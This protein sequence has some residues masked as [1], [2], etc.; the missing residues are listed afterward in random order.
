MPPDKAYTVGLKDVEHARLLE[1]FGLDA[2]PVGTF[3]HFADWLDRPQSEGVGLALM[4]MTR[5]DTEPFTPH[6]LHS[7]RAAVARATRFGIPVVA[8]GAPPEAV[9]APPRI[10]EAP[11]EPAKLVRV[12]RELGFGPMLRANVRF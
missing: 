3:G 1:R 4:S 6:Q 11:L 8:V 7:V 2:Y 9:E 10:L 12:L 5:P